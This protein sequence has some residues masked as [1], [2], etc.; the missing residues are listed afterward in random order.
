MHGFSGC[1]AWA[2]LLHGMW[3]LPRSGIESMSLAWAGRFLTT[4]PPRK[5]NIG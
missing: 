4:E 3:G 1:G 5:P 2:Q